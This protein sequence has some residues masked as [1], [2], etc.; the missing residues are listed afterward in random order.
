MRDVVR[1][2]LAPLL[3]LAAFSAVYGLQGLLCGHDVTGSIAG[4]PL[5]R[6]ILIAAY[7]LAI[8]LQCGVLAWLCRTRAAVGSRFVGFVSRATGW[9]GLVAT[10]WSLFPVALLSICG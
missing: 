5:P 8:A 6:V 9:T 2:M 4:L 10:I 7:G 1:I 3:W